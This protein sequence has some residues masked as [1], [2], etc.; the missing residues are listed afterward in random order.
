MPANPS[1]GLN[2]TFTAATTLPPVAVREYAVTPMLGGKPFKVLSK[3]APPS[4]D[5]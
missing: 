1:E 5:L 2:D 3:V 4:V